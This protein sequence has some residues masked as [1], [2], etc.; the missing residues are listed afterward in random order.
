V[1]QLL[2][3][4]KQEGA[5]ISAFQRALEQKPHDP[6]ILFA[7]GATMLQLGRHVEVRHLYD[8]ATKRAPSSRQRYEA[9]LRRLLVEHMAAE[10]TEEGL[11]EPRP[12]HYTP[13]GRLMLDAMPALISTARPGP[14]SAEPVLGREAAHT[15]ASALGCA[16]AQAPPHPFTRVTASARD[17]ADNPYPAPS[18]PCAADRASARDHA[19]ASAPALNLT[20]SIAVAPALAP[21]IAALEEKVKG[22]PSNSRLYRDLSILYLRAGRLPEAM[23][24]GR[25]AEQLHTGARQA[26]RVGWS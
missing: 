11:P 9:D 19:A 15:R 3:E 8:T 21:A 25:K 10:P 7:L 5:A 16:P 4:N 24:M 1:G 18:S 17:S 12:S 20:E 14:V 23:Q 6:E 22:Q 26:E 13:S 2:A